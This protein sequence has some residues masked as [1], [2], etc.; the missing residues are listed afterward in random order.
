MSD[1]N[2]LGDSNENSNLIQEFSEQLKKLKELNDSLK[3]KNIQLI[4]QQEISENKIEAY[5]RELELKN[6]QINNLDNRLQN[7][8]EELNDSKILNDELINW[9][10]THKVTD[11]E[12]IRAIKIKDDNIGALSIQLE[13][14]MNKNAYVFGPIKLLIIVQ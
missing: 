3:D 2:D 4:Q 9:K 1:S 5:K 10:E 12:Y 13:H 11:E 14:S 8:E 6:E 7:I